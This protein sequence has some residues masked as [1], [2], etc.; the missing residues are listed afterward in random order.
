ML[1]YIIN[2]QKRIY[3]QP[4]VLGLVKLQIYFK[5]LLSTMAH[6]VPF[7]GMYQ[8][9]VLTLYDFFKPC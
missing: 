1:L 6:R 7:L 2:Y 5:L 3:I 9:C 4:L 8:T